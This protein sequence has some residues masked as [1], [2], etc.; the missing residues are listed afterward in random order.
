MIELF[1]FGILLA[2]I[3]SFQPFISSVFVPSEVRVPLLLLFTFFTVVFSF[4]KKR[5]FI[6]LLAGG[7]ALAILFASWMAHSPG[8]LSDIIYVIVLCIF[9]YCLYTFLKRTPFVVWLL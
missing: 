7:I 2:V 6:F 1:F 9:T 4:K 3:F 5:V 8:T